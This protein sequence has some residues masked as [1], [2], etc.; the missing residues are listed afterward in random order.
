MGKLKLRTSQWL[1]DE[2]NNIVIG[3]GRMEILENIERHK[4]NISVCIRI[5]CVYNPGNF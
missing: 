5:W 4:S 3:K 1:V 2:D